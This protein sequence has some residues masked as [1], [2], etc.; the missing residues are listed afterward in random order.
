MG[1]RLENEPETEGM[2]EKRRV[3]VTGIGAITPIGNNAQELWEGLLAGKSGAATITHF[4]TAAYDTHFGCELK[5][6][7]ATDY[8]DRKLDPKAS[9]Y[10]KKKDHHND[11]SRYEKQY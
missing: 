7:K 5:G 4:D 2:P 11:L 8:M 10:W 6:F 3:V 9:T 1:P